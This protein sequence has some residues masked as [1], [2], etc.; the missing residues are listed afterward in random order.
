MVVDNR[1]QFAIV[2][3]DPEVERAV[4]DRVVGADAPDAPGTALLV[5]SGGCTAFTVA[6]QRPRIQLTLLDMN[7]AQLAL[8]ERKWQALVA[9]G[10]GSPERN[11]LFGVGQEGEL[12]SCGNFESLFRGWRTMVHD[13]IDLRTLGA[14]RN[15]YWPVSFEMFFG[16]ALLEAMFGPDATQHA[17][18]GSYP[19]YFQ[20][21]IEQAMARPDAST[22]PW[23]QHV[24]H[25]HYTESA[26]PPYL[27]A[28]FATEVD[29]G[30]VE[31]HRGAPPWR[32]IHA[33]MQE[34]PHFG[35]FDVISLSNLFD[36]MNADTVARIAGRLCAECRPHSAVI[37]RQLNNRAPVEELFAPAFTV[38][39]ALSADLH[40][41]DRSMFYE[42]I[43]V[44]VKNP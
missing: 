30:G 3:E 1:V 22:N 34:A 21:V 20:R 29:Q 19:A 32:S 2:R 11:R 31:G 35:A 12:T 42:R 8:V 25:G 16:D 10:P 17:P 15:K 44:L 14:R 13:L 26:V 18:K 43:L 39:Q 24:L 4:L 7:D 9:H 37:V 38:D 41:R 28:T 5:A 23:L 6:A 40:A 33:S 27:G 36:W